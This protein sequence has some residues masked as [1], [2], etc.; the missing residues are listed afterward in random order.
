M[1]GRNIDKAEEAIN[2]ITDKFINIDNIENYENYIKNII[3]WVNGM[4]IDDSDF[5]SMK[6]NMLSEINH[7][8][9]LIAKAKRYISGSEPI[10][11]KKVTS[12]K[13]HT[14][15]NSQNPHVETDEEIEI[16][17]IKQSLNH[18]I[19]KTREILTNENN[20]LITYQSSPNK[21]QQ[22]LNYAN[23]FINYNN[24]LL[25]DLQDLLAGIN[26]GQTIS[27]AANNTNRFKGV[28]TIDQ[29]EAKMQTVNAT[30]IAY[31]NWWEGK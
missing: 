14:G 1:I 28:S 30:W 6:N 10:P 15:I 23:K 9:P 13:S 11:T 19:G 18:D 16:S 29:Y 12:P 2:N 17:T 21:T 27:E 7:I 20:D 5:E 8:L 26:H 4:V 3:G 24:Q 22:G 31:K 25:K